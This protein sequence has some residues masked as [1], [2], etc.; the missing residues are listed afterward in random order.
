MTTKVIDNEYARKRYP[1][2]IGL[3][4]TPKYWNHENE[5]EIFVTC[6]ERPDLSGFIFYS[7]LEN[8]RIE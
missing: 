4:L 8:W 5:D 2:L 3:T 6:L 1:E 7:F